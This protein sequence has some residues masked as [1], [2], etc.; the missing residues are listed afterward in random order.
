MDHLGD[1]GVGQHALGT[2]RV[3]IAL[4]ELA[5]PPLGR[6]LAAKDRADGVPLERHTELVHM[7]GDEPGQRHRE[8]KPERQLT[9]RSSLVGDLE[10]LPEHLFGTG[11]LAGQHLHTLDVRGLDRHEPEVG[12][13]PPKNLQHPLARNHHRGSQ[14]PQ[15]A[16]HAGVN[17][18]RR[19]LLNSLS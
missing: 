16:G 10:D 9:R 17:H 14:V 5:E 12:E 1:L 19:I 7:L 15:P 2:D 3:E 18:G 11:S 8:I 6:P 4:D 13:G